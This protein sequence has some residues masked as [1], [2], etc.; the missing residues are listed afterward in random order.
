MRDRGYRPRARLLAVLLAV[1]PWLAGCGT[2]ARL[3]RVEGRADRSLDWAQR[4]A[5]PGA[6]AEDFDVGAYRPYAEAEGSLHLDLRRAL[7]LGARHS[8]EYQTARET[9][10]DT[11]LARVQTEHDWDWLPANAFGTL[12]GRDFGVPETHWSTDASLGLG[13]RFLSGA[14]LTASLAFQSLRYLSGDRSVSLGTL[15]AVTLTQPLLAG[16]DAVTIREPLTQSERNLVYALRTYARA[17][18][19]LVITICDR[20]YGVLGAMDGLEIARQNLENLTASRERSEAMAESGRVP[21]FQVDQARQRELDA[22]SSLVLREEQLQTRL[23][24]LKNALGLPLHTAVELDRRDLELLASPPLPKPATTFAAATEYA[25]EHR[26]DLATVRDRLEDARRQTHIAGDALRARLDL[27]LGAHAAGPSDD[28]LRTLA[29]D[30]G[31]LSAGVDLE[32]PLDRTDELIRYRRALMAEARQERELTEQRDR[33]ITDLRAVWRSLE[34]A[35]QNF[36]IQNLGAALAEK[37]IESTELLFQAGR[38]NI[39]EVLDSRDALIVARNAVTVALVQ[40]RM[41]WLRLLFQLEQLDPEP[42][43][44]WAPALAAGAPGG[45]GEKP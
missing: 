8:R 40:H 28:H 37:R 6:R 5:F 34:S 10:Y 32:L 22:R 1:V 35:E 21:I 9:L 27:A 12:V 31:A 29:L 44:L 36:R 7:H 24:S 30:D 20:Y 18:K 13:R 4:L 43:T 26:L 33:I 38:V 17:R 23:D 19:Q 41:D 45:S 2:A 15:A 3:R 16:A 14:R 42:E 25:L 39:R 11:A